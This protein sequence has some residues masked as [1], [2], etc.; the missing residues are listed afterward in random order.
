MLVP[1][2]RIHRFALQDRNGPGL[3]AQD[4]GIERDQPVE[5]G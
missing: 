1:Q 3:L 2:V 4:H 5:V